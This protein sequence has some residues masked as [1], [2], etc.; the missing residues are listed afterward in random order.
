MESLV[1]QGGLDTFSMGIIMFLFGRERIADVKKMGVWCFIF[2]L[3]IF[4]FRLNVTAGESGALSNIGF[5][6]Y[7]LLPVNSLQGTVVMLCVLLLMNSVTFKLNHLETFIITLLAFVIWFII[8]M[9]S[10]GISDIFAWQGDGF[11]YI[12]LFFVFILYWKFSTK[13]SR[14]LKSTSSVFTKLMIINV[15]ILLLSMVISADFQS[16]LLF[17][18][19][20]QLLLILFFVLAFL[21]WLLTEQRKSEMMENRMRT[22]EQ[23]VPIINELVVEVRAKQH[24]YSNRLLA[25]SSLVETTDDIQVARVKMQDYIKN[26]YLK[27]G[28]YELLNIDHPVIAG[29]LYTKVKR[30][31]QLNIYVEIKREV[32]ISRLPCEDIDLMEVLGILIDNAMEAGSSGDIVYVS[33]KAVNEQLEV[34]VSN[35]AD[36]MSNDQFMQLFELGYSTKTEHSI[37]RGYGLYHVKEIAGKYNGRII[38]RNEHKETSFITLGVQF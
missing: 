2:F 33:F 4:F 8:R 18:N 17:Q 13:I 37:E 26:A 38:A 14:F 22:T 35:P 23:Y 10:L 36:A 30:A 24:E 12:T 34:T 19:R 6:N 32:S 28:Q 29:F 21:S 5:Q 25:V 7:E 16:V 11:R 3:Y 31:E 27:N 20:M 9:L 15:F 1:L